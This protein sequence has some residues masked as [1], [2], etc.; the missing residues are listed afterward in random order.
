MYGY[1]YLT[2]NLIN[3]K[4]YI[5]KHR[6][7]KFEPDKYIGSGKI[8][9]EA[10]LKEGIENFSCELID[11]AENKEELNNKEKYWIEFYNAVADD[12]FYNLSFGGEGGSPMQNRIFINNGVIE[13]R[14][15]NSETI[16]EGFIIGSLPHNNGANIS[17]AK[18]GKK[19]WNKGTQWFTNG[20][21]DIMAFECPEGYVQGR[22]ADLSRENMFLYNNG[23]LEKYFYLDTQ[24][25]DWVRGSLYPENHSH[26]KGR[27][28]YN[29]GITHIYLE[30]NEKI[31][32]GFVQGYT[33]NRKQ[34]CTNNKN[35][36]NTKWYNNGYK[37]QQFIIGEQPVD[38]VEG[39]LAHKKHNINRIQ[40][41]CIETGEIF[42][43]IKAAQIKFNSTNINKQNILNNKCIKGFH[44]E[45]Y[46]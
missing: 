41:K 31:P 14:I 44:F 34:K 3:N 10:I 46:K 30:D 29:N 36:K 2:T 24:P 42:E 18:K 8:L 37:Q 1:I 38:W 12:N 7:T 22:S 4:K 5:G 25:K 23:I 33:K 6:A 21:E 16:P 40:I 28:C 35:L 19:S 11:T 26:N 13:K 9:K 20:V 27:K 17:A 45:Y 15:L 43:S 32:E 39:M